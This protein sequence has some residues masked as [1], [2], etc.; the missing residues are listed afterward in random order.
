MAHIRNIS[1]KTKKVRFMWLSRE[2]AGNRGIPWCFSCSPS[3]NMLHCVRCSL[4]WTQPK[5]CLRSMTMSTSRQ[6]QTE[7]ERCTLH[8]PPSCTPTPE[9]DSTGVKRRSG[10]QQ[11]SDPP[12][13]S[14]D[15]QAGHWQGS[16]CLF[17][18]PVRWP[19]S[20]L[21][22]SEWFSC[23]ASASISLSPC[24]SVVVAVPLMFLAIIELHAREQ[25]CWEGGV[26]LWR[27][28]GLEYVEKQVAESFSMPCSLRFG[29]TQ[30][31]GQP[32]SG[33]LGRWVSW[34]W[35]PLWSLHCTA[36]DQPT[37]MPRTSTEQCC[38][39]PEG[40][41][42]EP[43]LN[44]WPHTWKLA[45]L[46]WQAKW[47]A[48]GRRKLAKA[49]AR[50]EPHILR[51][52]VEQAWRLHWGGILACAAARAFAPS[53]LDLRLA[54]G[55]DGDVPASHEVVNVLRHASFEAWQFWHLTRD[56]FFNFIF[57]K[58]K[59]IVSHFFSLLP[60]FFLCFSCVSFVSPLVSPAIFPA[61]VPCFLLCV[62]FSPRFFWSFFFCSFF[63]FLILFSV[64]FYVS[65][66]LIFSC[67]SLLF[68]FQCCVPLLFVLVVSMFHSVLFRFFGVFFSL[69][70]KCGFSFFSF[71]T[72]FNRKLFVLFVG[73]SPYV[74]FFFGCC[75]SYCVFLV[76]KLVSTLFVSWCFFFLFLV[77]TVSTALFYIS[78]CWLFS[79]FVSLLCFSVS[80][81]VFLFQK[82]LVVF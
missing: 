78:L 56:V 45:W 1:G 17:L 73:C 2:K 82:N 55:V 54:G 75:C 4:V 34:P 7:W 63:C 69:P 80:V 77:L 21:T 46:F 67:F 52:R 5:I 72:D 81:F 61:F 30:P 62:L 16:C 47:E 24:V 3:A 10:M 65:P 35:T 51:K 58:K 44:L 79:I 23:V 74:L 32:P 33:D 48:D 12:R 8:W 25:G 76:I 6:F 28:L 11:A 22:C 36:M 39:Q 53:L 49:K 38:S 19:T 29:C 70:E 13:P 64:S 41:K 71:I 57:R 59:R 27:A 15:H 40:G 50:S 68:L 31:D 43:T 42:K 20:N 66:C 26:L 14:S 60:D 9:F 37:P 18:R